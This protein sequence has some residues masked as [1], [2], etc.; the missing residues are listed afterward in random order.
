LTIAAKPLWQILGSAYLLG[1]THQHLHDIY[2]KEA[3]ELE[4]WHDSPG[5]ISRDD[6]RDFLG[7]REYVTSPKT[8][9]M[10]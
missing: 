2:E 10:H 3:A 6:W 9:S 5:E 4:P 8:R 7:K 1:G